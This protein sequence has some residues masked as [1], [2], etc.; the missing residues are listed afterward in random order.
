MILIISVV[1]SF[2]VGFVWA[3]QLRGFILRKEIARRNRLA[4]ETRELLKD[5]NQ[6]TTTNQ[7]LIQ[8]MKTLQKQIS[9][10]VQ[11]TQPTDHDH[12][13]N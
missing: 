9:W 2:A 6:Q 12:W 5:V 13:V 11:M 8:R 3:W 7:N 10:Q 1:L 4:E